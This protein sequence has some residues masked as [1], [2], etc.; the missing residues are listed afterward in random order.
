MGSGGCTYTYPI[1]EL[2]E[3]YR[4]EFKASGY[5][6]V[7]YDI[8]VNEFVAWLCEQL[9]GCQ[10]MLEEK[11]QKQEQPIQPVYKG[12]DGR[13]RFRK[14]AIVRYLLD[15]GTFDMNQIATLPG[16]SREDREQFAQLIGYSVDGFGE[17]SYVSDESY[18]KAVDK[19]EEQK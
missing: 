7:H 16:I 18:N 11:E 9:E 13:Y 12:E 14:N 10:K 3:K 8:Q 15:A 4:Q 17:L 1:E 5:S 6:I 19:C 2:V